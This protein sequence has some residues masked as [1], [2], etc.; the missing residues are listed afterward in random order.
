V[1]IAIIGVLIALLLPA[2]QAAREAA[3]RMQC[4]NH[5]KQLGLALHNYHDV[6][7]SFPAEGWS[8]MH[9]TVA[10]IRLQ[11]V[12]CR[13]LPFFEQTVLFDKVKW[14]AQA[15]DSPNYELG[16]TRLSGL[17]CPSSMAIHV[18]AT[19]YPPEAAYPNWYTTHYYANG[20]AVRGTPPNPPYPQ[21][22]EPSASNNYGFRPMTG[23]SYV[24]STVTFSSVS[25][26]SSNSF[27]FFEM[28][29]EQGR[30]SKYNGYLGWHRGLAQQNGYAGNVNNSSTSGDYFFSSSKAVCTL[31][32]TASSYIM[33]AKIYYSF[34]NSFVWGSEHPGG[35]NAALV[36]GSAK[37]VWQTMAADV[38]ENYA[39]VNDGNSV[40]S[41]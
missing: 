37:F 41:L 39:V 16:N 8:S 30:T 9:R 18:T 10:A 1:V 13:L 5:L 21:M 34:R 3:R 20:G 38:L 36:D 25:D 7:N 19:T 17:L 24:D 32:T 15:H 4:S 27:A 29:W 35:I 23:I 6:S 40:P 14:N 33:N 28:S 12:F 22:T 26:G 11:G 31:G 2:V